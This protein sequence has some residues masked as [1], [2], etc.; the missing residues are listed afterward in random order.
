MNKV[1]RYFVRTLQFLD[2]DDV[3]GPLQIF[4]VPAIVFLACLAYGG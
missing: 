2:R 1:A 4:F 3:F